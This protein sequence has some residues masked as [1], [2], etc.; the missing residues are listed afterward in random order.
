[1]LPMADATDFREL[2]PRR[3]GVVFT[4]GLLGGFL[5]VIGVALF[6]MMAATASD[7][8]V[9]TDDAGVAVVPGTSAPNVPDAPIDGMAIAT[10]NGC[11][12]CHSTDGSASVGPTWQGVLGIDRELASGQVVVGEGYSWSAASWDEKAWKILRDD[13]LILLPFSAWD[14]HYV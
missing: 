3:P 11:L 14:Y 7:D 9:F 12:A 1:M 10:A 6:V 4:F 8:I 13:E 5:G 2:L